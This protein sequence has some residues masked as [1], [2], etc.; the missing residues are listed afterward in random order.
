MAKNIYIGT[1]GWYYDH[2]ENVLY[3]PGTPKSDRFLIYQQKL[4]A[5][6]I[7]AT[8]YRLP[9]PN[10]VKGWYRK[11]SDEFKFVAKANRQI[12]HQ[13]KL[14][15]TAPFMEKFIASITEL[16]EKLANIL[17]QLPPSLKFD[18]QLLENFLIALPKD[19]KYSFEFRHASWERQETYDLLQ[20]YDISYCTV[21]RKNYPFNEVVTSDIVYYRLHGPEAICASSYSDNWLYQ[22][23]RKITR[24]NHTVFVFFNND[25]G[26]HA[27]RNAVLLKRFV[28]Q[29]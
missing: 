13:K 1:S 25:I 17:F 22:L 18:S 15:E 28:E 23:A 7:N 26:G 10:V 3:P 29:I 12:T 14:V 2:W 24:L 5:V 9:F 20:H 8:F 27:V 6:E 21:S 4:K 19:Y 11:S 16:K